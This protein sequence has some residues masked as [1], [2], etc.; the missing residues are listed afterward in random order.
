MN[1]MQRLMT[2][3][4]HQEPDRVPFALFPSLRGARELSMPIREYYA[5][6]EYVAEAQMRMLRKFRHDCLCAY[7]YAAAEAEA[8]GARTVFV[9]DGPPNVAAPILVAGDIERLAAPDVMAVPGLLRVLEATRLLKREVGDTVPIFGSVVSPFSLPVMQMGFGSYIELIY[10]QPELFARL[11]DVNIE[12]TVQWANAQLA[13][14]ATA[15]GYADPVASTTNISREMYLDIA[16]PVACRT[17][18]R[19]NGATATHMA[20]GRC[21]PIIKDIARSGSVAV[22][23]SAL[24]DLAELKAAAG[25]RIGLVG[26]LNGIEMRR[27]TREQAFSQVRTAIAKAGRGGGFVLSDCHGEIP[28]QVPDEVLFALRDALECWGNYPLSWVEEQVLTES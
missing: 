26:N 24:E 2:A 19:I 13:A 15:I 8:W 12:F 28:W 21:L 14:G 10:G 7:S 23:V 6:P 16:Y 25:G 20:S 5:K 4:S 27:W 11:M 9:A 3:L 17:F 1:S 18:A 22:G